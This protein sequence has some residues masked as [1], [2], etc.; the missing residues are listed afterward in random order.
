MKRLL[1][2]LAFVGLVGLFT[3]CESDP[4]KVDKG[5]LSK[6]RESSSELTVGMAKD[7]ALAVY[8]KGNT[9]RLSTSTV[10]AVA[11]EEW[12]AEAYHDDDWSKNR[13][14]F[15]QFLYFADGRLVDISDTRIAYRD[16][17]DLVSRWAGGDKATDQ[18]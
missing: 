16:N 6:I 14:L 15:V 13:D 11:I 9:V 1:L 3:A 8:K 10:N 2:P 4:A 5:N 7:E 17:P 18:P 12:K